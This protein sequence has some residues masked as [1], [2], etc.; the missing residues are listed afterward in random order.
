MR[1]MRLPP[2][3]SRSVLTIGMPPATA[4]SNESAVL[5]ASASLRQRDAVVR[6]QRLVGGDHRPAGAERR[7]DRALGGIALAAHQFDE[8][9]DAGIARERDRIVDLAHLREIERRVPR[10]VL[11]RIGDELDRTAGA[12]G[13]AR[14]GCA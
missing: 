3:P 9:V 8:H 6:Q 4:A 11:R 5:F 2:S 10:R 7:L 13:D 1:L 14:R 12:L